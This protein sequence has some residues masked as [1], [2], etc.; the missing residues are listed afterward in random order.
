MAW[1]QVIQH[2][3]ASRELAEYYQRPAG[4]SIR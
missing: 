2:D 3:E 4:P 1:I